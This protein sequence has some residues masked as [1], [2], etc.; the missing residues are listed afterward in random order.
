MKPVQQLKMHQHLRHLRESLE[1]AVI[2]KDWWLGEGAEQERNVR[3]R[4]HHRA[5]KLLSYRRVRVQI[6]GLK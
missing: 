1:R 6:A 2:K 4:K 5:E 3:I